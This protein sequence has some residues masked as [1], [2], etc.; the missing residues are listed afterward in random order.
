MKLIGTAAGV[1][2]RFDGQYVVEYNPVPVSLDTPYDGGTLH[3]S[4]HLQDA[5]LFHD[6]AEAHEYW[7]QG[8]GIERTNGT[9]EERPLTAWAIEL[10]LVE[11]PC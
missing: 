3:T 2:T 1:P 6:V 11:E 10:E 7:R 5:K 9:G 8:A 4:S